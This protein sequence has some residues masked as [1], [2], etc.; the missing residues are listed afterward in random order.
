M[1]QN[2]QDAIHLDPVDA[3]DA[4]GRDLGIYRRSGIEVIVHGEGAPAPS[5]EYIAQQSP[6]LI[7]RQVTDR[8][9][10]HQRA[11]AEVTGTFDP[12]TGQ[13]VPR[14]QGERR[15]AAERELVMLQH[16]ALPFA[17]AQAAEIARQ[18]AAMPT[19]AD[20]MQAE[21]AKRGRIN[22]RALELA[23]ETEAQAQAERILR[24]RRSNKSDA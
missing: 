17:K 9:E 13:A 7:V 8:I 3:F 22:A 5:E 12:H 10:H 18:Q 23:E 4:E 2:E 16:S 21:L 15:A 6:E 20:N 14:L 19:T 1:N 24:D 11:L